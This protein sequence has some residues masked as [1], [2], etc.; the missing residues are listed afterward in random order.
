MCCIVLT[1][2]NSGTAVIIILSIALGAFGLSTSG[3]AKIEGPGIG[4]IKFKVPNL[5]R[6]I[7]Q[8]LSQ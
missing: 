5:N 2:L 7:V 6:G 8:S 4:A 1:Q 3:K